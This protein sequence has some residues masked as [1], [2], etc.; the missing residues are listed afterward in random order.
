MKVPQFL[1]FLSP[2]VDGDNPIRLIQGF[3]AGGIVTMLLG[4]NWAN[5]HLESTVDKLVSES[6]EQVRIA[7]LAPICVANFKRAA[8]TD[9]DLIVALQKA[10]SW[11]REDDLMKAGWVTFPGEKEPSRT[12]ANECVESLMKMFPP[13]P[14]PSKT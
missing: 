11:N 2:Y 6:N 8:K 12:I 1:S 14:K 4:F 13:P 10:D 3:V 5:W 7:A 9:H